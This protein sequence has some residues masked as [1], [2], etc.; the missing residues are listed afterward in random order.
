MARSF[1]VYFAR[2]RRCA[3]PQFQKFRSLTVNA[4]KKY[5]RAFATNFLVQN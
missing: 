1:D 5:V 3:L 4:K 2:G